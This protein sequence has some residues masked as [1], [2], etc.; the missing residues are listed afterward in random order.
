MSSDQ[1]LIV[2]WVTL[3]LLGVGAVVFVIVGV[4]VLFRDWRETRVSPG[5]HRGRGQLLARQ[6]SS[7]GRNVRSSAGPGTVHHRRP[8]RVGGASQ[9]AGS[10]G[11]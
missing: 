10:T 1:G 5:R 3:L 4:G 9:G 2:F 7:S 11:R 8:D 6:P